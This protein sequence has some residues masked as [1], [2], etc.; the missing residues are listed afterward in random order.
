M[1][2]RLFLPALLTILGL[3]L[4]ILGLRQSPPPALL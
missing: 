1:R 2:L 3:R 4:T